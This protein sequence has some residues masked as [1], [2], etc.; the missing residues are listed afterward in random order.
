MTQHHERV[1]DSRRTLLRPRAGLSR[2]ALERSCCRRGGLLRDRR[3][4]LAGCSDPGPRRVDGSSPMLR[5]E[6]DGQPR[7]RDG[8]RGRVGAS[9]AMGPRDRA[10]SRGGRLIRSSAGTGERAIARLR[11]ARVHRPIADRGAG[12][13]GARFPRGRGSARAVGTRRH[14]HV[15]ATGG[16]SAAGRARRPPRTMPSHGIVSAATSIS[17]AGSACCGKRSAAK[18]FPSGGP[19]SGTTSPCSDRAAW[20]SSAPGTSMRVP[21]CPTTGLI[22]GVARRGH[23]R[24]S[25]RRPPVRRPRPGGGRDRPRAHRSA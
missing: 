3:S 14:R 19:A 5:R 21:C 24:H 9:V 15:D 22:D 6:T 18:F 23:D 20:T 8:G 25:R 12:G 13:L 17:G 2:R 1:V 10:R 7:L 16:D 4:P 11:L